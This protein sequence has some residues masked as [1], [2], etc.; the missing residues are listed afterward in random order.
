MDG[1]RNGYLEECRSQQM[2]W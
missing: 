2:R 1:L